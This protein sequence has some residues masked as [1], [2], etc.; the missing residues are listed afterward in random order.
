MY[1]C[2][3]SPQLEYYR[4]KIRP[5]YISVDCINEHNMESFFYHLFYNEHLVTNTKF[6]STFFRVSAKIAYE[7]INNLTVVEGDERE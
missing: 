3:I 6:I 2:V 5:Y 1:G 7:I 4:I